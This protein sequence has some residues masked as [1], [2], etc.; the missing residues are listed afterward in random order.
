MVFLVIMIQPTNLSK[1]IQNV[2]DGRIKG[3]SKEDLDPQ[4]KYID[5]EAFAEKTEDGIYEIL[6][7]YKEKDQE[8][9]II[10]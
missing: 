5:P 4:Q 10:Y 3:V 2:N 7:T 8:N 1:A 6:Q 9:I